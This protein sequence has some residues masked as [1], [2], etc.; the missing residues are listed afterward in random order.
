MPRLYWYVGPKAI[1]ARLSAASAGTPI[2][3]VEDLLRW[4][5][6]RRPASGSSWSITATFVVDD[7]GLLRV[8]DR[9]SEHFACAG[10]K[11]V[12]SAG[13]ITFH[14]FKGNAEVTWVTNQSAG[15]CPEPESWP[16]VREALERAKIA[17][18][19]EF[20]QKM[21]FRRCD[22]CGSINIVK[23]SNFTCE[24]CSASL[25]LD[26]NVSPEADHLMAGEPK[27]V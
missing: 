1:A 17:A 4:A 14:I 2:G 8:A 21:V 16:S 6:Q 15:Y 22:H 19:C 3:S 18:P 20:S 26:W 12:Q 27:R 5:R 25:P 10:G 13:E 9:R 24:V 23:D 7:F 11:L